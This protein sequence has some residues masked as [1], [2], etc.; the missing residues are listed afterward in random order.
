MPAKVSL[1]VPLQFTRI[2]PRCHWPAAI[3]RTTIQ[4]HRSS[5]TTS[6]CTT[7][8][9]SHRCAAFWVHYHQFLT[10]IANLFCKDGDK[11]GSQGV[12]SLSGGVWTSFP[13]VDWLQE[14]EVHSNRQNT[15]LSTGS[16][17]IDLIVIKPDELSHTRTRS[18]W[19]K[20][21]VFSFHTLLSWVLH[22]GRL[23]HM[24]ILL[25]L[26]DVF[27]AVCYFLPVFLLG[28][29]FQLASRPDV[30]KTAFLMALQFWWLSLPSRIRTFIYCCAVCATEKV[31]WRLPTGPLGPLP[32]PS[33]PW[34]HIVM[35][36]IT[37]LPALLLQSLLQLGS[38]MWWCPEF[39]LA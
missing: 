31:P 5:L 13:C 37:R 2:S 39:S 6:Q 12:V 1:S 9:L 29:L 20:L 17:L 3:L 36:F 23:N 10:G 25:F 27:L 26:L 35:D 38:W 34:S 21:V 30:T 28:C 16:C 8:P 4:N 18:C 11:V 32:V 33:W 24:I 22:T 19:I 7:Y 15:Q 14:L